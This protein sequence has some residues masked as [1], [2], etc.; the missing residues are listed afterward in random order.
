M[1]KKIVLVVPFFSLIF[2]QS[3]FAADSKLPGKPI[4]T[5]LTA[6]ELKLWDEELQKAKPKNCRVCKKERCQC[7]KG[8]PSVVGNDARS[9]K[10]SQTKNNGQRTLEDVFKEIETKG[11]QPNMD[12]WLEYLSTKST[13]NNPGDQWE[14]IELAASMGKE[15]N[16]YYPH[17]LVSDYENKFI[18]KA[19]SG[20]EDGVRQLMVT[21]GK[22]NALD[23][24]LMI[25]AVLES[26]KNGYQGLAVSLADALTDRKVSLVGRTARV[27]FKNDIRSAGSLLV[28]AAKEAENKGYHELAFALI[29]LHFEDVSKDE[30]DV[31][32]DVGSED[33][34]ETENDG[35]RESIDLF[36]P[37]QYLNY[38]LEAY[39]RAWGPEASN[40]D[41]EYKPIERKQ[42]N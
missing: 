9:R 13:S 28:E 26:S 6:Q 14:S 18:D 5:K 32:D 39:K 20:D 40:D 29:S 23:S 34:V 38:F 22:L 36:T 30:D 15:D 1:C 27:K 42:G 12:G 3:L 10:R 17:L 35:G 37:T 4:L 41:K 33:D 24:Q 25:R 31:D 7:A 21:L 2:F 16:D 19:K 8:A 11:F